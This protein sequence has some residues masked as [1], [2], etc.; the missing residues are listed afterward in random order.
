[1]P[2]LVA[3]ISNGFT[4]VVPFPN[5]HPTLETVYTNSL[6]PYSGTESWEGIQR[7][8]EL[9][10]A[11]LCWFPHTGH[12]FLL[13]TG[14]ALSGRWDGEREKREHALVFAFAVVLIMFFSAAQSPSVAETLHPAFTGVQQYAGTS[15]P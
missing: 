1:M 2:G 8:Q 6:V 14:Q 15:F 5:G 11:S 9:H 13:P 3:P 7:L 12:F 10:L 4:G